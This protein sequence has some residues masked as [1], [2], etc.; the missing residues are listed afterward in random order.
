MIMLGLTI[1]IVILFIVYLLVTYT[2]S[3]VTIHECTK[4]RM[5]PIKR[6]S[7]DSVEWS[8]YEVSTPTNGTC[9]VL[10]NMINPYSKNYK[11]WTVFSDSEGISSKNVK[12]YARDDLVV[13]IMEDDP[14]MYE[15]VKRS[16]YRAYSKLLQYSN[17]TFV[18][19]NSSKTFNVHI[20]CEQAKSLG[21]WWTHRKENIKIYQY[22]SPSKH[23]NTEV[24]VLSSFRDH[25]VKGKYVIYDGE[26]YTYYNGTLSDPIVEYRET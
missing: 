13:I 5:M 15:N 18:R 9:V 8:V 3:Y 16:F 22:D 6:H 20:L 21:N 1:L 2:I 14:E 19:F 24:C 23:I 26:T 17:V 10:Q 11:Y 4:T 12:G 7:K 25:V